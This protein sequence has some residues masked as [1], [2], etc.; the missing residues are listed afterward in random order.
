MSAQKNP[1][2]LTS[3]AQT[4]LSD[5]VPINQ[6]KAFACPLP[7]RLPRAVQSQ[8]TERVH[9]V[10]TNDEANTAEVLSTPR[11]TIVRSAQDESS[12]HL[13]ANELHYGTDRVQFINEEVKKSQETGET[14]G[15]GH[16][17]SGMV[18]IANEQET[19]WQKGADVLPAEQSELRGTVGAE[20]EQRDDYA[21]SEPDK[22]AT[23]KLKKPQKTS[24]QVETTKIGASE[25]NTEAGGETDEGDEGIQGV[26]IQTRRHEEDGLTNNHDPE[27][28]TETISPVL[29]GAEVNSSA[30]GTGECL[31]AN[32][33]PSRNNL[34]NLDN[35]RSHAQ[36]TN[37]PV[38][39]WRG[40]TLELSRPVVISVNNVEVRRLC[41]GE[42]G[43][44]CNGER[45]EGQEQSLKVEVLGQR[46][47]DQLRYA[48]SDH[49]K[50][51][52]T[53]KEIG[54]LPVTV[55]DLAPEHRAEEKAE[56]R[57][58]QHRG[59]EKMT[60]RHKTSGN[61]SQRVSI[62]NIEQDALP[63]ATIEARVGQ[64]SRRGR[65]TRLTKAVRLTPF[66]T[67]PYRGPPMASCLR[68]WPRDNN[69]L[70]DPTINNPT[71]DGDDG[72]LHND[73][74]HVSRRH[75][76]A[77]DT[78]DNK[79]EREG[80]RGY[81]RGAGTRGE[82]KAGRSRSKGGRRS[83]SRS[84]RFSRRVSRDSETNWDGDIDSGQ[85]EERKMGNRGVLESKGS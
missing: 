58:S 66:L 65:P 43:S 68:T 28:P 34:V 14:K 77:S 2:L 63:L 46:G 20:G 56:M 19:G 27:K 15:S 76:E 33:S 83:N 12:G 18:L 52:P 21:D 62:Q 22:A 81:Y 60:T 9:G 26:L 61:G 82:D 64:S 41:P 23:E 79:A 80:R 11:D 25:N 42:E 69:I 6:Q 78:S 38:V 36:G 84:S 54:M 53:A 67:G 70:I 45:R 59:D 13:S 8:V 50:S 1:S 72:H 35:S 32:T 37:V 31:N 40:E 29:P 47:Q 49:G 10:T 17:N 55:H 57:S 24:K 16:K 5:G 7:L 44:P 3:S 75:R 85:D 48:R 4:A 30:R 73:H 71:L 39:T 74:D 51:M